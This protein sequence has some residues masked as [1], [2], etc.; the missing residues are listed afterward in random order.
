MICP[1]QTEIIGD[2]F[3]GPSGMC[4]EKFHLHRV[5][6]AFN[7]SIIRAVYNNNVSATLP[8]RA[9]RLIGVNR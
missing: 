4:D 6:E 3:D 1:K 9:Q 7:R 2:A 8:R 5:W